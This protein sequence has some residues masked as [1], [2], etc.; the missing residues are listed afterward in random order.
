MFSRSSQA[1]T[2]E[3]FFSFFAKNSGPARQPTPPSS[4][5]E[6]FA[7]VPWKRK[8]QDRRGSRRRSDFAGR[9]RNVLVTNSRISAFSSAAA[10]S[11]AIRH[12]PASCRA[13]CRRRAPHASLEFPHRRDFFASAASDRSPRAPRR[14]SSVSF[15]NAS[16]IAARRRN[17]RGVRALV[18]LP[19]FRAAWLSRGARSIWRGLSLLREAT[20]SPSA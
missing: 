10:N 7:F 9:S 18:H 16:A 4:A 8:C 14:A 1:R 11:G 15:R 20:A 12:A 13:G 5:I 3:N 19:S 17:K 6:P 2:R